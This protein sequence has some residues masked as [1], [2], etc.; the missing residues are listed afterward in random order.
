MDTSQFKNIVGELCAG[1][2]ATIRFYGKITEETATRFN[3]EFDYI[4]SCRPS[5]IRVLINCEGGF[6]P[7]RDEHLRDDPELEDSDRVRERGY[8]ASMGSIL[9]RQVIVP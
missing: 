6:R 2:P 1:E 9:W 7:A 4:E 5:L 8:A 3:N